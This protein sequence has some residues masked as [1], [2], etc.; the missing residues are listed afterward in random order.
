MTNSTKRVAKFRADKK[1]A[2]LVELRNRFVRRQW[3]P[4]IDALIAKLQENEK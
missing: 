2:G 4:A 3:I 1:S